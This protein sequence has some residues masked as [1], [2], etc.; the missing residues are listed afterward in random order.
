MQDR[1]CR[2]TSGSEVEYIF[3]AIDDVLVEYVI[4]PIANVLA[5]IPMSFW[6]VV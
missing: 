4:F 6:S 1:I 3:F 5:A 2:S